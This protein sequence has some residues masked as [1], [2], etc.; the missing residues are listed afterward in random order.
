L[1]NSDKLIESGFELHKK[2]DV[3]K[4]LKLYLDALSSQNSNSKLLFLIGTANLQI[5]NFKEAINYF[6]KTISRDP[7]NFGAFN[8]LGA[9]LQNL[10]QFQD[11]IVIYEKLIKINPNFADAYSNLGTCL[12]NLNKHHEAIKNFNKAVEL[13]PENFIA[14]T[15]LAN[16]QKEIYNFE[17]AIYNYKK[18]ISFNKNYLLAY[19]NLANSYHELARYKEAVENYKKVFEINKN[20]KFILGRLI[21]SQMY[22]CDWKDFDKNIDLLISGLKNNEK[23]CAPFVALNSI[24]NPELQKICSE[25]NAKDK[26]S[27]VN[28]DI[29]KNK[30][31]KKDKYRIG[32]FSPDFRNHP[33]LHLIRDVFKHHN[34]SKFEIYAFSFEPQKNDEMTDEIKEYFS[35]FIE[36]KNMSSSDIRNFCRKKGLDIAIDLCGFTSFNRFE[37]FAE[38]LAPIQINYLGYP[39]TMGSYCYDYII[40][41]KTII[42]EEE[43]EN[44]SEK[45]IYLPNCYQPNSNYQNI[46]EKSLSKEKFN[47]AEDKIIYCNLGSN[48]KITPQIFRTWMNILKKVPNS[49]LWLMKPN[50]YA[51]KNIED[52]AFKHGIGNERIIF[53]ENLPHNNHLDRLR[54]AD[55]FLDTFPYNAHTTASDAIRMG[56]PIVTLNGRSFASRVCTSILNQVNMEKLTTNSVKKYEEIAI[57]LGNNKDELGKIKKEIKE[58]CINSTLFKIQDFTK[59]LEKKFLNLIEK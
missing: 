25:I 55:I 3:E 58:N 41:D 12:I 40:A 31:N 33:V 49:I 5:G 43:K 34:K 45:I 28:Y 10:K 36:V 6:K 19:N 23:I 59:D 29:L 14:I 44:Y 30:K 47:L 57:E 42:P 4:A 26:A 27:S 39:G 1:E 38:R 46:E 48:H 16:A 56:V 32:Y 7:N 13:N 11:A 20:Y 54:L 2:G 9:S 24:D 22:L 21:H 51:I 52:E 35:E 37:I 17:D 53:A 8:N 15:N 50:T 18:A